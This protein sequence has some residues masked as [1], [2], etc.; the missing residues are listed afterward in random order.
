MIN[1]FHL[2]H[3]AEMI[4][5][6]AIKAIVAENGVVK[7]D[8]PK[9]WGEVFRELD[10]LKEQP[11]NYL[12]SNGVCTFP[13]CGCPPFGCLSQELESKRRHL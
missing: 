8:A 10:Q 11:K 2:Q 12:M 4:S 1:V 5:I 9:I 7:Y 13:R 3:C 6:G